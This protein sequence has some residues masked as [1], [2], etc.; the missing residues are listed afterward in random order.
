MKLT[1]KNGAGYC[2]EQ[3][4]HYWCFYPELER[5]ERPSIHQLQYHSF[6]TF[7]NFLD[8]YDPKKDD[9]QVV[10]VDWPDAMI[11]NGKHG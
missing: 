1:T 8:V 7:E 5:K 2:F 3:Y 11:L 9:E 10:Q 6:E 4:F